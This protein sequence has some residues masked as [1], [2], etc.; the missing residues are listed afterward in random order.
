[1]IPAAI[2]ADTAATLSLVA[3]PDAPVGRDAVAVFLAACEAD[4]D[5][6]NGMV[7]VSRVR[8]LLAD[9]DIPPKR[10][11]AFWSHFTGPGRPMRRTGRWEVCEGSPSRNNGKPYPVRRWVGA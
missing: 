2:D 3:D 5:R 10:L 4:A 8:A 11:S 1:M 6:H 9:A 7:S